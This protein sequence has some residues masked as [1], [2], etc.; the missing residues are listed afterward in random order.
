MPDQLPQYGA[1]KN[2]E[3]TGWATNARH[4]FFY[5][6]RDGVWKFTVWHTSQSPC[7]TDDPNYEGWVRTNGRQDLCL[8]GAGNLEEAMAVALAMWRV[9]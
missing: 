7:D 4:S 2:T 8:D 5:Y 1:V 3:Y 6:I 9:G